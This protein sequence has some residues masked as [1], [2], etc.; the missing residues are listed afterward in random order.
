MS[1][2][3]RPS[4]SGTTAVAAGAFTV[5]KIEEAAAVSFQNNLPGLHLAK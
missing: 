1:E 4:F 3:S 5:P 2:L